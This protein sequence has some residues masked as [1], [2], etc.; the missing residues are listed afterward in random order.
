MGESREPGHD[1]FDELGTKMNLDESRGLGKEDL[2]L[3]GLEP[4]LA[5]TLLNLQIFNNGPSERR[6]SL[7]R[8]HMTCPEKNFK[9]PRSKVYQGLY[10]DERVLHL[11]G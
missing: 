2:D 1:P 4:Q 9:N 11:M 3:P 6:A 5:L 10:T 8:I 7:P